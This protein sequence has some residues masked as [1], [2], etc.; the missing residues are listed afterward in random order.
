MKGFKL[1]S[2]I[3]AIGIL[4]LIFHGFVRAEIAN[5]V[6]ALVNSELITL[7]ELNKRIRNVTG[8]DPSDLKVKDERA[9]LETRR[10][11]LDILINEK[12]AL[13][14][15]REFGIKVT[16]KE[17]DAAIERVKQSNQLTQEDLVA[18]LKNNGM[19]YEAYQEK[20]KSD[21]ERAQL[22]NFEVNS[23]III[24][25]EEI[26]AYYDSHIDQFSSAE[27]VHL[28]AI[29]LKQENPSNEDEA[30]ALYRKG[31]EIASIIK[32]GENFAKIA[33]KVSQG[34]GAEE[35]GNLG[36]F[37]V[38]NLDPELTKVLKD[39]SPGDVSRPIIRP[40]GIQIIQLVG[41][42]GGRVRPFEEVRDAIY[43]ILYREEINKRYSSWI[44]ELRESAYLKIIF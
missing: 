5:R 29:F 23:K 21:L 11:I 38:S 19:T 4:P 41:R 36:F 30:L 43:E 9:Y 10:Q 15:V 28:A 22:I 37:K 20:I 13:E 34:P 33:K 25:D 14:K 16:P 27:K 1:F 3:S 42:E 8:R 18:N 7:Y 2:V 12:I 32:G 17:V 31:E 24:R 6:V 40:S 39:M 35:G 44:K 26:K